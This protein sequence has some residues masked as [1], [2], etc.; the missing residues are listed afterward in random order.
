[1]FSDRRIILGALVVLI[2]LL[3]FALAGPL[4]NAG[5]LHE[6]HEAYA[7]ERHVA[8]EHETHEHQAHGRHEHEAARATRSNDAD[9][10]Y[11]QVIEKAFKVRAGQT[12]FLETDFGKVT[13][14]GEGG[15]E[16]TVTITKGIDDVSESRAE[17]LFDRFEIDFD[18]DSDGVSVEGDY[19]GDRNWGR[20]NRL[21][22][23]YEITIP[24]AFD[25]MVQTAGGSIMA[26]HFEG[27]AEL[28][29]AGGSVKTVDINGP[30]VVKTSGGSISAED[31]GGPA[32]L[33]TSGGS[34]TARDIDGAVESQ[35][36]GGSIKI[37]NARGDVEARTSGGSI[38]LKEIHGLANAQTS[39][40]SV[41]AELMQAPK[42]PMTLKTSGGTVT[43]ELA[44]DASIDIDAKA[45][46]GRVRS[47]LDVQVQG[48]I[49]KTH[50]EGTINGGGPLVTLRS[51]GGS[52]KILKR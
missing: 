3:V 10:D 42:G 45:S 37:E 27:D 36:S 18:Q 7:H 1:M 51:S 21:H 22:V 9:Y 47:E 34:I 2:G 24:R 32:D 30:V 35:T 46:G 31:L 44:E 13:V 23:E 14:L 43:L 12:L 33:H 39:G 41:T 16:V 28:R 11:V 29:T 50:L 40:G 5:Y 19:E 49:S 20:G 4:S 8:H 25:V 26:A 6:Y 48:E 38:R 52:V 17:E 15:D